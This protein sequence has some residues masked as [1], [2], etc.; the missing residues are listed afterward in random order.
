ME[1]TTTKERPLTAAEKL[2]ELRK[3]RPLTLS[4]KLRLFAEE[5]FT[6]R[7]FKSQESA[8]KKEAAAIKGDP[9]TPGTLLNHFTTAEESAVKVDNL[10]AIKG[11]SATVHLH[12]DSR[13]R[14]AAS[15][16]EEAST[17]DKVALV[18]ALIA[19][20]LGSLVTLNYQSATSY[21]KK[22]HEEEGTT[23]EE[24]HPDLVGLLTVE[25]T[26]D[27]RVRKS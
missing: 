27:V 24:K 14:V 4:E 6:A 23:L 2:K 12:R 21:L 26:Y 15:N 19:E 1:E 16:G 25:T 7:N 10:E 18:Q 11:G 9:E 17:E 20:G 3:E 5:T 13:A 8:S 22:M